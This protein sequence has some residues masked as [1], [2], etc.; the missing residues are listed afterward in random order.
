MSSNDLNFDPNYFM[1]MA[2]FENFNGGEDDLVKETSFDVNEEDLL[3]I[4]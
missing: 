4:N 1:K 3:V 2:N